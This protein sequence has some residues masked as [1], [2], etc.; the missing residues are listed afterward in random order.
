M[1]EESL[2]LKKRKKTRIDIC[3]IR[4][5]KEA[6]I[7]EGYILSKIEENDLKKEISEVFNI[8][9]NLADK[10]YKVIKEEEHTFRVNNINEFID[11]IEKIVL[12][13]DNHNR[14]C[15]KIN[16]IRILHIDREEYEREP[17]SQDDV[18]EIIKIIDDLKPNIYSTMKQSEKEKIDKLEKELS[19]HYVYA[20]DIELLKNMISNNND[21][22]YQQY[23]SEKRVKT[24]YIDIP[25]VIDK[26]YIKPLQGTIEYH[27]HLSNNIPRIERLINNLNKYMKPHEI[28]EKTFIIDQSQ[29]LQDTINI[30]IAT[31]NN[32]EFKAISGK[33]NVIGYCASPDIE[34]V[35]FEAC[36]VN[37]LGKL[38]IGYKRVNDSEKKIFEEI[39]KQ[40]ESKILKDEG[41]LTL[42]SKWE[43]CPSC[44][45]VISQFCEKYP[46]IK[47]KVKYDKKYGE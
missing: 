7:K 2:T 31:F 33:N 44:Y 23:N 45:Y 21:K 20:K 32:K 6:S 19:K 22:I 29:A 41:E 9:K 35:A 40:I 26:N 17:S 3:N 10:L 47:V 12:F 5:F 24:L 28:E 30:A 25:K 46:K 16:G 39:N 14:L 38:G 18:E 15:S 42:Y 4:D 13:E 27:H 43:P 8:E 36:K 1:R 34:K 37:K 11:Y